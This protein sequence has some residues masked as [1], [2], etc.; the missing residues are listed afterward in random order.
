MI[1][2]KIFEA[3]ELHELQ[4]EGRCSIYKEEEIDD[5]TLDIMLLSRSSC[6]HTGDESYLINEIYNLEKTRKVIDDVT[7]LIQKIT[8]LEN[9]RSS[10]NEDGEY[11][12]KLK[13]GLRIVI[14]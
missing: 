5:K 8:I 2:Q 11:E 3:F 4:C 13:I 10:R 14:S 7:Y 6:E 1:S 9:E 12:L